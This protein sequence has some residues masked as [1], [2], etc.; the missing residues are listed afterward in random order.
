MPTDMTKWNLQI[1]IL[2]ILGDPDNSKD[3]L[4]HPEQQILLTLGEFQRGLVR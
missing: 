3:K 4:H 1:E 2:Y